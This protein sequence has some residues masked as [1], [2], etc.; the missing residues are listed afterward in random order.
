[1]ANVFG[2]LTAITLALAAFVAFKNK[3]KY[4]SVIAETIVQ[5]D[6]LSASEIRLM[7]AEKILADL[8]VERAGVDAQ[9]DELFAEETTRK[10]A[11]EETKAQVDERTA[12]IAANKQQ[13]DEIREKTQK[14]GDLKEL[15]AILRTTSAD[16]DE[17]TESISNA[18]AKLLNLT[19]QHAASEG[20]VAVSRGRFENF[21]SGQSL[22]EMETRIR[23]I[24]PSWGFVTL[25][26]G[27][28]I[29]VV[30]NSV[31][32]V[33]RNGQTIAMLL[34]TAV[35]SNSA[36]ASII[37]DSLED[38]VTLMVGDQVVPGIKPASRAA[39]S[40]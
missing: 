20:Q 18:D 22:P 39:A 9:A 17:L 24:Y 11:N 27:N 8:P 1:M 16:L 28:N 34:V 6:N 33:I 4:T 14:T 15:A 7:E 13:L 32:N 23:S 31:L 36:S 30:A 12:K 3:G 29:G 5:R 38:D 37:P 10:R 2:I 19:A 25:A 35:E 26:G 21:A 40:N